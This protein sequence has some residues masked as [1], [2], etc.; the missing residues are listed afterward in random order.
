M[1]GDTYYRTYGSGGSGGYGRNSSVSTDHSIASSAGKLLVGAASVT[2]VAMGT[3]LAGIIKGG[4]A[5]TKVGIN[6][7]RKRKKENAAAE[8]ELFR[9]AKAAEDRRKTA[10]KEAAERY[11]QQIRKTSVRKAPGQQAAEFVRDA[12]ERRKTTA[13]E[14]EWID[15]QL[16][17]R[18]SALEKDISERCTVSAAHR[19]EDMIREW[20]T[21]RKELSKKE[22]DE[23]GRRLDEVYRS[24][25]DSLG[26]IRQEG[27]LRELA[28][29]ALA[30][31]RCIVEDLIEAPG[32]V[33]FSQKECSLLLQKLSKA[34]QLLESGNYELSFAESCDC[35][36]QTREVYA[37]TLDK[38]EA[39][40][41]YAGK[42]L[43]DLASVS[44]AADI[45]EVSFVHKDEKL[46]DDL[47]R[48]CPAWYD[49]VRSEL[50]AV[51]ALIHDGMTDAE[52][53][54]VK[55][56]IIQAR[57]DYLTVYRYAWDRLLSSYNTND[58][59]N[60]SVILLHTQGYEVESAAYES[61]R[62]KDGEEGGP[63]H[64]NLVNP[65]TDDRITLVVDADSSDNVTA[66]LH[67]FGT[68]DSSFPD[69]DKQRHLMELIGN[70]IQ[71]VTGQQVSVKCSTPHR[72]SQEHEQADIQA[73]RKKSG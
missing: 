64:I 37:D 35:V 8:N 54:D 40:Q 59:A 5:L 51:F 68:A 56:L 22:I 45:T 21:R 43:I 50:N 61:G 2:A 46:T 60:K 67:Q 33:S 28:E 39:S 41:R 62:D 47:Y 24:M 25:T 1:S 14:A 63:L 32:A 55:R 11:K 23:I 10:E 20:E 44:E 18:L 66:S 48:F 65:I 52:L 29:Q 30:D 7:Y 42:L 4:A 70:G 9:R 19:C 58:I 6:A 36:L 3:L 71:S 49:A 72:N 15:R 16:T 31:A 53:T 69:E 57:N 34:S 13:R 38:Y 26:R 27:G 73:Q 12:E 17:E